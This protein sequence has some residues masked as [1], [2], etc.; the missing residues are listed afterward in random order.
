M[1]PLRQQCT[2]TCP[3]LTIMPGI[4]KAKMRSNLVDETDRLEPSLVFL[5]ALDSIKQKQVRAMWE[6]NLMLTQEEI[7]RDAVRKIL[8]PSGKNELKEMTF[9][10]TA[11]MSFAWKFWVWTLSLPTS[12]PRHCRADSTACTGNKMTAQFFS[13][14][15]FSHLLEIRFSRQQTPAE[16][17]RINTNKKQPVVPAFP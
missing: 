14:S 7:S 9:L 5:N 3:L 12:R 8:R 6:R 17:R 4:A 13:D 15:G 11:K 16:R 2:S 10:R 1:R